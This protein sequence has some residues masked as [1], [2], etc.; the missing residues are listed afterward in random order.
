M[1]YLHSFGL[2]LLA[3][4]LAGGIIGGTAALIYGPA[5]PPSVE[6]SS[7]LQPAPSAQTANIRAPSPRDI[8]DFFDALSKDA[9][10]K[11]IKPKTFTDAFAKFE[12]DLDVMA[13]SLSQP[14]FSRS[15]GEYVNLLV[16]ET[17]IEMGREKATEHAR[18]LG[19]LERKFGVPGTVLVAIWGVESNFGASMGSRSVIR[20]L[21]TLAL[22]DQRRPLFWRG[23]L[24][25][26]L[27]ILERGDIALEQFVGSWA[28]AMGHT[29]FIPSTYLAHAVDADGDTK[30]NIWSSI[31][32]ALGS[33][34]SYLKASDWDSEVPWGFEVTLPPNHDF[35]ANGPGSVAT[36]QQWI[37]RGVAIT[38]V[39]QR[40]FAD[41]GAKD[42][43]PLTL[44]LPAGAD[45]PAFLTSKNFRALLRYNNAVS[46]ALAVAH[47]S[48]RIAGRGTFAKA[49]PETDKALSRSE[50]EELQSLLIKRGFDVGA[51]DGFIGTQ[52]RNAIRAYQKSAGLVEDGH[53]NGVLLGRLRAQ[54]QQN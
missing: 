13:A 2:F 23:E 48:D 9:V 18:L 10:A 11:G 32:D 7:V 39:K 36:I 50:R 17:R 53:P 16:S 15:A 12:P 45:G 25:A 6:T 41:T 49:W 52:T 4:V 28:G 29:Q 33:T 54:T 44:H 51:I 19:E 35:S 20:S 30:R 40:T 38:D 3:L 34:A 31:T 1:R 21:A 26:A 43:G 22:M 24:L 42:V 14:E 27:T 47:L 5:A 8:A 46:Y 37:E